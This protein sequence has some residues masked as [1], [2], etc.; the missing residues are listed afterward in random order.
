MALC[1]KWGNRIRIEA[2][3]GRIPDSMNLTCCDA[4]IGTK[5]GRTQGKGAGAVPEG[6]QS[7]VSLSG[8]LSRL[9]VK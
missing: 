3:P 1:L 4:Q 7:H 5:G 2:I 9:C 6:Y 8:I